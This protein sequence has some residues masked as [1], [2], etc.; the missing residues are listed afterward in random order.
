MKY[1]ELC[2]I[3]VF[4]LNRIWN[5]MSFVS[6]SMASVLRNLAQLLFGLL[7]IRV[8]VAGR[9][10]FRQNTTFK[11]IIILNLSSPSSIWDRLNR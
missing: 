1:R 9:A 2:G 10:V 7:W 3:C 6:N 4:N 8:V 5:I 11:N